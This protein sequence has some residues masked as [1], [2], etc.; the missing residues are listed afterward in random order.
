MNRKP[1]T[2]AQAAVLPE[3]RVVIRRWNAQPHSVIA[4]MPENPIGKHG[5]CQSPQV[6][7]KFGGAD[8]R[9]ALLRS[10]PVVFGDEDV[11]ELLTALTASG[12][13]E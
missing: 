5:L 4:L 11:N 9:N 2:A 3:T 13:Q 1:M 6:E 12:I 10:T 7:G 8:Y